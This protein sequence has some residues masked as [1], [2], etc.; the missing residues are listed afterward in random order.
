MQ[1]QRQGAHQQRQRLVP[2]VIITV[3]K[4][5]LTG[6]QGTLTKTQT[7]PDCVQG[8]NGFFLLLRANHGILLKQ[9]AKISTKSAMKACR[10]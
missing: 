10:G 1:R 7:I 5:N 6:T 2:G 4:E 3:T 9:A 8:G